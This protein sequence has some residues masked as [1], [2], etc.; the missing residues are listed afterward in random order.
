MTDIFSGDLKLYL[1]PDG[2]DMKFINGQPI[3][4]KGVENEVLISL[5]TRPGWTGN[6]F[7]QPEQRIG[8][9]FEAACDG[10]NITLEK[11]QDIQD[12]AAAALSGR[13]IKQASADV[14]N[15]R[16]NDLDITVDGAPGGS[17]SLNRT[18]LLW[19]AQREGE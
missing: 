4:E 10:G 7:M 19:T 17:L 11:L 14:R 12:A 1:T 13:D 8:S 6:I 18:G 16:N 9:D 3:M 2:A 15:P 5:F